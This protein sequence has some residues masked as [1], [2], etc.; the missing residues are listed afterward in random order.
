MTV[1][2]EEQRK[3]AEANRLAALAKRQAAESKSKGF[4]PAAPKVV[5]WQMPKG[6]EER[7]A[8]ESNNKELL[9]AAPKAV[10]W[11]MPKGQ[12]ERH[13]AESENKGLLPAAPKVVPWQMPKGQEEP[14]ANNNNRPWSLFPCKKIIKKDICD[15]MI[16][17][18]EI[19]S[20][21]EFSVSAKGAA[22]CARERL[23]TCLSSAIAIASCYMHEGPVLVVCP[24]SMRCTWAEELERWLPSC[25]PADVHLVFGHRDNI[26]DAVE[27]PKI[28]V[29]SY[30]M[31]SRLQKSMVNVKWGLVIIDESHNLRCTK[32]MI[33]REETKAVLDVA[34]QIKRVVL[35]S[36]TPSLSRPY[37]IFHQID[38]LWPGLLGK[39]KYDF[40]RNYCSMQ[41]EVSNQ[42]SYKDFSKGIRLQELN[43]LLRETVMIRRL[44]Q[45]VLAQLPPKRRQVIRLRL[46]LSDI[47]LAKDSNAEE[48]MAS[49]F[50][51]KCGFTTNG[52]CECEVYDNEDGGV[53]IVNSKGVQDG[54]TRKSGRRLSF[55]E[56]GLAK[57]QSFEDWLL[58]HPIFADVEDIDAVDNVSSPQ[59]MVVFGHHLR[60]LD[61]IQ[62]SVC[63]KGLEFVR[64]DGSTNSKERQ[65]AVQAFRLRPE[66]KIAI[67]GIT[68]GGV[69]LDFSTAQSIAFVE[70]PKSASEMIQAEDRAHRRG[71]KNAV[72]IYIFCAKDTLDELH[73]RCLNKSLERTT[74]MMNG[75][76]DC[77][78]EIEVDAV[79]D[80]DTA[81]KPVG[82]AN[83]FTKCNTLHGHLKGSEQ[84]FRK[85]KDIISSESK[86]EGASGFSFGSLPHTES[87]SME[88]NNS[89]IQNG[90][91]DSQHASDSK[92]VDSELAVGDEC[93]DVFDI[94][95]EALLFEVSANTGRIHLYVCITNQ[96]SRPRKL[97]LNFRP[98]DFESSITVDA[99]GKSSLPKCLST[100]SA[101]RE[102][103]LTFIKEWNDLRPIERNKLFGRP[104]RLPLSLEL[105]CIKYEPNHGH[106]GLLKGGSK[107]RVA[108]RDEISYP[109]PE[110]ATWRK[111]SLAKHGKIKE[112]HEMQA[113]TADEQPL[114]KLCQKPCLGMQAKCPQFFED[115][116]CKI[117]CFEEYR[118]R[119][120]QQFLREE[121]F[122]IEHG[123]CTSCKLD[124]HKLVKRIQPLSVDQRREHILKA[125]PDF[126]KH[127]RL[128]NKL[129]L[130][131]IEGNSWHADHIVPVYKGGG[132]CK[133]ENMR[134]LCVICHSK[135]TAEQQKDRRL[136][137]ERAKEG[138]QIT[139][140]QLIER[141]CQKRM[142]SYSDVHQHEKVDNS[143][144]SENE[145]ELLV[146]VSG[147]AYSAKPIG[148]QSGFNESNKIDDSEVEMGKKCSE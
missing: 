14:V 37:D 110:N 53:K 82:A 142:K 144:E 61:G 27:G 117:S 42:R 38:M 45:N 7:Q 113:W 136:T 76:D 47:C 130:E 49:E 101:H 67:I 15:Q 100:D 83:M 134:T 4:L 121:L 145:K 25:C 131:P 12:E 16:V 46:N 124:C 77:V 95:P 81:D 40:A 11:Q 41:N 108:S 56:I 50:F 70:L 18:M 80:V 33:E 129:V 137:R 118:M 10:P 31:L 22:A 65:E 17:V 91:G 44:K 104:L 28:V 79:H 125:A 34:G 35:L 97:E 21:T 32:K 5:P 55:Q 93:D 135:V 148:I 85:E 133:L 29:I 3:R 26:T 138:L 72:N 36:G 119:T 69:G 96:D 43:V 1:L 115:L 71:Q 143:S 86:D 114:C 48:N 99:L 122:N 116:F 123:I 66:V 60:V 126:V 92:K 2:T 19:C 87:N 89:K 9:P 88:N 112:R 90:E 8:T 107:R 68:A 128:L 58:Y 39:N 105:S 94:P 102:I 62:K 103:V 106:G 127:E 111:I 147:S 54:G 139:I 74:T 13:A 52:D 75:I 146:D 140:E 20:A 64:I 78:P 57:L 98:E 132:E 109:L 63:Q 84:D 6:Q 59:K 51:C 24:A 141:V 120:S 23:R 30:T 73:W